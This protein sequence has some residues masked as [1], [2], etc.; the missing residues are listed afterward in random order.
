[1]ATWVTMT[2]WL[3]SCND[4]RRV[5]LPEEACWRSLS[6]ECSVSSW[7]SIC[8]LNTCINQ[9]ALCHVVIMKLNALPRYLYC[10]HLHSPCP[11]VLV[12]VLPSSKCHFGGEVAYAGA[13]RDVESLLFC[14]GALAGHL[15]PDCGLE[16]KP[17]SYPQDLWRPAPCWVGKLM[18]RHQ[19]LPACGLL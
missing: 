11:T 4:A 3:W 1:M 7:A 8:R 2:G 5:F 17:F 12:C 19:L 14:Q 18:S 13:V 10:L 6:C 9:L 15:L 16:R